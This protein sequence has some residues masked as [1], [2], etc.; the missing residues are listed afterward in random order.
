MKLKPAFL[1]VMLAVTTA[2]SAQDNTAP[3]A[4]VRVS[5]LNASFSL[6]FQPNSLG[7]ADTYRKLAPASPVLNGDLTGFESHNYITFDFPGKNPVA[8]ASLGLTF[9]DKKKNE[10]RPFTLRAGLS[11]MQSGY[12]T[13]LSRSTYTRFDTL[14]SS[15]GGEPVYL[16]SVRNETI[17]ARYVADELR[18][19]V[20]LIFRTKPSARWGVYGGI[21]INAGFAVRAYTEVRYFEWHGVQSTY[22]DTQTMLSN[23]SVAGENTGNPQR[24]RNKSMAASSVYVPMGI[25]YRVANHN[26]FWKNM[27]LF[28]EGRFFANLSGIDHIGNDVNIGFMGGW[29]MRYTF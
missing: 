27:H 5:D 8:S 26:N 7:T 15:N 20:S 4:N 17:S 12:S 13:R 19:D 24:Y 23:N 29:G 6:I 10:Y 18:A 28:V 22:N 16:D 1:A 21:G 3:K 11:Y 25:D 14:T 9:L 2:A